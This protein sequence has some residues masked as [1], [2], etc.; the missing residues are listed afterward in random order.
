MGVTDCM[1]SVLSRA[2]EF[3]KLRA[4]LAL[5][6]K[7]VSFSSR[8]PSCQRKSH[9]AAA[10]VTFVTGAKSLGSAQASRHLR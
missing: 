2:S 3:V 9:T 5:P 6:T 10:C 8:L 1:W 7:A 4:T